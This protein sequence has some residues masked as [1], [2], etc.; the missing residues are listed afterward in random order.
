[1]VKKPLFT[2]RSAKAEDA[3]GVSKVHVQSWRET[4]TNIVSHSHLSS[5]SQSE[6]HKM[7]QEILSESSP[8]H[9]SYVA[10]VDEKIIGFVTGGPAREMAYEYESELYAL[11]LLKDFHGFGIGKSLFQKLSTSLI[12][13]GMKSMYLWVLRENKSS[14]FY[15]AMGGKKAGEKNDKIIGENLVEDLYFWGNDE[16]RFH[17][18]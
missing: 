16:F 10:M 4:Y 3:R 7:W 2:I 17:F 11:Y 1:M 14:S 8:H 9:F 13:I 12:N 6:K 15:T 18:E 5:L